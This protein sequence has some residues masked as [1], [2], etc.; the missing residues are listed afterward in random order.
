MTES[1]LE[2]DGFLNL[3]RLRWVREWLFKSFW[4]AL[5]KPGRAAKG[6]LGTWVGGGVG[7]L[8]KVGSSRHLAVAGR[9]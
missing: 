5:K 3:A 4:T 8:G 1:T 7:V 9:Q 2:M 6:R